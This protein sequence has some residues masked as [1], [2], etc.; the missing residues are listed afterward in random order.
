[1]PPKINAPSEIVSAVNLDIAPETVNDSLPTLV[2]EP[3]AVV[4]TPS[5]IT[6]EVRTVPAK[7]TAD[8]LLPTDKVIPGAISRIPE[9]VTPAIVSVASTSNVLLLP[10][11]TIV[12]SDKVP[13]SLISP[14][15]RVVAPLYVFVPDKVKTPIPTFS[16]APPPLISPEIISS[17]PSPVV[18][19]LVLANTISPE[20]ETV[21]IVSV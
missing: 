7:V 1:M 13:V 21:L 20:P 16:K 9:P 10:I 19:V 18:N 11:L 17:P 4:T 15:V 14:V 5:V 8:E 6:C 12:L 2:N 3:N